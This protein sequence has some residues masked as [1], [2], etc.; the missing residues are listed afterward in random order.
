MYSLVCV[1]PGGK[2]ECWFSHDEAHFCCFHYI[3]HSDL[4]FLANS[5][6]PCQTATDGNSVYIISMNYLMIE[7]ISFYF[8]V[9]GASVSGV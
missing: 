6:A 4:M 1:G 7:P 5:I 9:T 3:Y 2:P 8:G